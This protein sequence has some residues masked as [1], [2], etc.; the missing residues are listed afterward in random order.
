MMEVEIYIRLKK[1]VSDPQGL[2]VKHALQSLGYQNLEEVR[3]GKFITVKLNSKDKKEA[4][5][6][7]DEMCQ[8]L[9]AN[10]IIEDYSFKI[11]EA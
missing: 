4:K 2:T 5:Q 3:V 7:T 6:T 8:K 1:T 11:E 9:L 10:P